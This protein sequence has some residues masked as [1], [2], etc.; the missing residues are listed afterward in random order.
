MYNK[1]FILIAIL[2]ETEIVFIGLTK[3][4]KK[5]SRTWDI[6]PTEG[7]VIR[8]LEL[9]VPTSLSVPTPKLSKLTSQL[10]SPKQST[11]LH[12]RMSQ[13]QRGEG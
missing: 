9:I 11:N 4:F 10:N 3:G 7:E 5:K 6:V 1:T 12:L 8:N 13:V 2:G